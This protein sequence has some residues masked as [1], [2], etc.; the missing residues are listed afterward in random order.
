MN[1]FDAP[2]RESCSVSRERTNTPLQA[3]LLMNDPQYLEAARFFAQTAINEYDNSTERAIFIYR[4]ALGRAP[5]D[6]ELSI[7]TSQHESDLAAFNSNPN[8][9]KKLV[10]IGEAAAD[11]KYDAA[12]LASWTLTASLI[13]NT[14]EFVSK[15]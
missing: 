2:S 7:V 13:M 5:T 3:L 12:E 4:T 9:A 6:V 1:I 14:D 8:E 11:E 15:N 10:E